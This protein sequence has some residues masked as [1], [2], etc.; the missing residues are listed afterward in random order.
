MPC[1]YDENFA[2][3]IPVKR[4]VQSRKRTK[5]TKVLTCSNENRSNVVLKTIA[6]TNANDTDSNDVH[7]VTNQMDHDEHSETQ[8]N[9]SM[10]WD[11]ISNEET[12]STISESSA[13]SNIITGKLI[14]LSIT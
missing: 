13:V 14:P 12:H 10:D 5:S 3:N 1:D 11:T 8:S 2:G 9:Q 4:T 6:N 7:D